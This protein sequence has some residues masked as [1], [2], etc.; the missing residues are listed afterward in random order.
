MKITIEIAPLLTEGEITGIIALLD[1]NTGAK[2]FKTRR[3]A[4]ECG[5][6]RSSVTDLMK[7]IARDLTKHFEDHY[8][9][10][11]RECARAFS[12]DRKFLSLKSESRS[13][14]DHVRLNIQATES[15]YS[16]M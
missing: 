11:M 16:K 9:G 15:A 10:E 4:S 14:L 8:A 2:K 3:I 1:D 13:H 5:V 12:I 7:F 6:G